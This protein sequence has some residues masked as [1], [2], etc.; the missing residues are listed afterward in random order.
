MNIEKCFTPYPD[1]EITV[2]TLRQIV[3]TCRPD[4]SGYETRRLLNETRAL[5]QQL[6]EQLAEVNRR[7]NALEDYRDG[8]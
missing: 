5:N 7:L 4:Y 1:Y 8:K 6:R 3:P 2:P